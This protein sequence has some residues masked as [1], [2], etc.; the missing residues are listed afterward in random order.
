[1]VLRKVRGTSFPQ[2]LHCVLEQ[3]LGVV[4]GLPVV[5]LSG[6]CSWEY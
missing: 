3:D 5:E 1:M 2:R 4:S 6:T